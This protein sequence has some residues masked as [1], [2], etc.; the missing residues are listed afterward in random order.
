MRCRSFFLAAACLA[1]LA[2]LAAGQTTQQTLSGPAKSAGAAPRPP[3]LE[4][5]ES[6]AGLGTVQWEGGNSELEMG[7]VN[8]DGF[9]DIVAIGDHGSPFIN[10]QEHGIM[11]YFGD[12]TG[13]WTL[14][15]N[16][17]FGYGGIALGDVNNDGHMDVGYAMHH[18][19]SGNDFGDQLIEVSLGD[20]TGRNWTP[21][22]DG[23]ATNGET[24]GMF[25]T[26][27]ADFD[28]DGD[29]DLGSVSFGSGQGIHLYRNNGDGT[30]TQT[31]GFLGG[32]CNLGC[33]FGDVNNDGY[34]D[35]AAEQE[36]GTVYLGDGLGGF[37]LADGNLPAPGGYGARDG[38][39]LGDVNGDGCDDISWCTI[40]GSLEVW[41][42]DGGTGLWV[43]ASK[44]LPTSS[45]LEATQLC[46]MNGDGRIDLVAFG[47]S[48]VGVFLGN[49]AGNWTLAA[50]M[51]T[52]TPGD[53]SAFRVGGD[54][55]RNGRPDIVLLGDE[56]GYF[57]S[58]NV[59][60]FYK[61]TSVPAA[62]RVRLVEPGGH[63]VMKRGSVRFIDWASA[64][65]GGG[66]SIV[67]L[68]LSTTGPG[69]SYSLMADSLP[70][71]GRFQWTVPPAATPSTQCHIRVTVTS[72]PD[73]HSFINAV[74]FVID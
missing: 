67:K 62:L 44:G 34:A 42:F 18:D 29:L 68:E 22:D 61:E 60:H 21:W 65:P 1:V 10:T 3:A 26:D 2:H 6:S 8:A 23:L 66:P 63:E 41:L 53:C 35:F 25:G 30:W 4:Y 43:S 71:N 73:Q 12:G 24:Y 57:N 15:Q 40:G 64:V 47:E 36:Y 27:F 59:L 32:N 19:Y 9:I 39:D 13:S 48:H 31:F 74:P 55:D 37:T 20:G 38:V 56:G 17:N 50:Y 28:C 45:P 7:D 69:G 11:V 58:R 14:F 51:Q 5:V 70:D 49:G 52:G 16:G 33:V 54:A 72:G 46:D